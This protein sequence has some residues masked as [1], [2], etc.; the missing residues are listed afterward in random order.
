MRP[1]LSRSGG[2]VVMAATSAIFLRQAHHS[3]AFAYVDLPDGGVPK[4]AN[5]IGASPSYPTPLLLDSENLEILAAFANQ[6]ADAARKEIIPYWRQGRQVLGQ[7]IKVEEDRS[8]FQSA[9]PVTLADRAAER[10]MRELITEKFPDHGIYGEEYGIKA[11]D[12]DWVWVLDPIDGTRSFITGKP[13]FGTLIALLHKGTPV[14]GIIDQCVLNERWLGIVGKESTLNEI[15]IKTDGVITLSDAEMYSTTPDMFEHGDA[16]TKFDA[17]RGA[18]RTPHYGADCYAYALVASGFGADIVVEAD[19]GLYDYCALVPIIE[20]AGGII[21]DWTGDRLTLFNH[22]KS[23]GR[24]LA[25]ANPSLHCQA[26]E[27]LNM[28]TVPSDELTV[29]LRSI[30]PQRHNTNGITPLICGV[31]IGELIAQ[32]GQ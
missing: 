26:L 11:A 16:L 15:P 2:L 20:G 13:L 9:S 22:E 7:Q 27:I 19:L 31:M 28:Q 23:R 29:A 6:L 1:S 12:A 14:I 4:I 8:L 21:T 24:V 30:P 3:D 25:S 32:F 18:V 17:M 10:A 5:K